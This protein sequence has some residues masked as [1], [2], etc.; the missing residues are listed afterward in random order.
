[1]TKMSKIPT[2]ALPCLVLSSITACLNAAP[3]ALPAA[4]QGKRE[5]RANDTRSTGELVDLDRLDEKFGL[6]I[7]TADGRAEYVE[8]ERFTVNISAA[9]DCYITLIAIDPAGEATVLVPR[10]G[11]ESA[12]VMISHG[13]TLTVP[14][15]GAAFKAQPPHG[16]TR[17]KVIATT[18]PLVLVASKDVGKPS[19]R[20]RLV[21]DSVKRLKASGAPAGS[22]GVGIDTGDVDEHWA[23][24][25]L[26]LITG[27]DKSD[28]AKRRAEQNRSILDKLRL[29]E[30]EEADAPQAA[31]ERP[32]RLNTKPEASVMSNPDP[33]DEYRE[34]WEGVIRAMNGSKSIGTPAGVPTGTKFV[35]P[36]PV[37]KSRVEP[38]PVTDLLVVRRA[39]AGSKGGPA[40][41]YSTE[42]V[43][44][45]PAGS[46]AGPMTEEALKLRIAEL[47]ANDP[48]ITTIIPNRQW[49]TFAEPPTN[50]FSNLQWHLHND[51]ASDIDVNWLINAVDVIDITPAL[52][53]VVDQ[54]VHLNE[55]RLSRFLWTNSKEI[56]GNGIDDDSNGLIDD[57]HGW[58]F[59]SNS[60]DLSTD[61]T[62]FNH[63]TYC[64]SI[65]VGSET[66]KPGWF[67]G[68]ESNGTVIPVACMAFDKE[69]G[70]ATGTLENTLQAIRYAADNGAKVI[71]LSL[72][73]S[74]S[75]LDIALLNLHPL[76]DEL[77]QKGVL[78]VIAAGN[79]NK[80]ID[81]NPVSPAS[82]P[83][84][85]TIVV[86]AIDPSGNP[87]RAWDPQTKT[88][89]QYS[90]WGRNT[91]HV[92]APGTMI[93]GIPAVDQTSYG[94]GTSFAAPIVTGMA[95]VLW[96]KHPEWD[97]ATVRRAILETVRP[98]AGLDDKCL[99]GG[100]VDLDAAMKFT[101]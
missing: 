45:A 84:P 89:S 14:S 66:G 74:S 60:T 92:A 97:V 51:V 56:P 95:A 29:A 77:E 93:L 13:E 87:G 15:N 83:R 76:F 25:E 21:I 39:V 47:R 41:G 57:V 38:R 90:N 7:A 16:L 40:K 24:A 18:E 52:V 88:W 34:R 17:L 98:I 2:L 91:V 6:T 4:P 81:T 11:D 43:P 37:I 10:P 64:T 19:D 67:W 62:S 49:T 48:T 61:D 28:V 33:A 59:A 55:T 73:G 50:P 101:P 69:S 75:E 32:P 79:E 5:M 44:L 9:I 65:I 8:G 35:A 70:T 58:N 23:T 20:V 96:G 36:P 12:Q 63:G 99:T 72:G 30:P 1:M 78:L 22:K 71:N 82:L 26:R 27:K 100:M 68:I 31:K 3:P 54:G 94:D 42:R 85:N 80:D 53:G 86:M 46:K